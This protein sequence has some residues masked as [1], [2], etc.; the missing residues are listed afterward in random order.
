MS[1]TIVLHISEAI[2]RQIE[3]EGVAAFPSECCGILIGRDLAG[4]ERIVERLAPMKNAFDASEQYHRFTI[5][6]R[7]QIEA[8]KSADAEGKM[9]LGYYHSHPNHPARPSEY[10][11]QNMPP[12]SFYSQ[13]IVSIMEGKPADM[14]CWYLDEE[15]EQFAQT[16]IV[17][18]G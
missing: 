18:V 4:G 9:L 14:T 2:K 5:D 8:E 16:R 6:P 12:F 15:T 10:D 11:R 3:A 7:A 13:V 17:V 1:Q